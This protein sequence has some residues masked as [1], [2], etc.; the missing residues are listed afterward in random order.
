MIAAPTSTK[1]WLDGGEAASQM[2]I[3][4]GTMLGH[5]PTTRP[6]KPSAKKPSASTNGAT[7]RLASTARHSHAATTTVRIGSGDRYRKLGQAN[8]RSISRESR[9]GSHALTMTM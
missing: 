6:R 3:V 5:M 2:L 8:Q 7:S 9:N 1:P 4:G